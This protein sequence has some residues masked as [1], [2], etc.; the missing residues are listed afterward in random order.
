VLGPDADTGTPKPG[1]EVVAPPKTDLGGAT[2]ASSFFSDSCAAD[3]GVRLNGSELVEDGCDV[4]VGRIGG[5]GPKLNGATD[6][7][8]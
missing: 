3:D 5:V 6:D 7:G 2:L 4:N 1:N 8:P